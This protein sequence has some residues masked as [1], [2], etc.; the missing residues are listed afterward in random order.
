M[1]T[2]DWSSSST[3]LRFEYNISP[4]K[5]ST[6]SQRNDAIPQI[7]SPA[8]AGP[9]HYLRLDGSFYQVEN[10]GRTHMTLDEK[11][12]EVRACVRQVRLDDLDILSPN[13]LAD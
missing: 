6:P 8:G 10:Y 9:A 2:A 5:T 7:H 3:K 1:T 11:T 13:G 12:G 4:I